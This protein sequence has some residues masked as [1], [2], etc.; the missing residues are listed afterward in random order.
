MALRSLQEHNS[1]QATATLYE[2]HPS[3]V[4]AWK[5]PLLD[6][7]P[8]VFAEGGRRKFAT[9]HEAKIHDLH[10]KI[11][12]VTASGILSAWARAPSRLD[13]MRMIEQDGPLCVAPQC[14]LLGANRSSL[15]YRPKGEST[16]NLAFMRH[17]DELHIEQPFYGSRQMMR[18]LRLESVMAGRLRLRRLMRVPQAMPCSPIGFPSRRTS[19]ILASV[20]PIVEENR[21]P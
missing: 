15:Y 4:S 5:R 9:E 11:G 2:L 13:R 21:S 3:Q 18:P 10:A 1:A 14:M 6:A 16:E 12:E 8:E 20:L 7:V 17:L 19:V